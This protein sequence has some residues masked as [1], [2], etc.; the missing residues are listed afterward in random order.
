MQRLNPNPET[1]TTP[2]PASVEFAPP[3]H[4]LLFVAGF[5]EA[6]G[7]PRRMDM[8][9]ET[10]GL[11][12]LILERKKKVSTLASYLCSRQGLE[13]FSFREKADVFRICTAVLNPGTLVGRCG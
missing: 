12:L 9:Q 4:E 2:G 8:S 11:R 6:P 13:T 7:T 10:S 5:V 3:A 1:L